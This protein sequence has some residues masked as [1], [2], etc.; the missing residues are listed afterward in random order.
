MY[1]PMHTSSSSLSC[2]RSGLSP[3]LSLSSP[4]SCP[5][6][7]MTSAGSNRICG[8]ITSTPASSSPCHRW[9]SI[10]RPGGSLL[11]SCLLC[12]SICTVQKA[13][14]M[15]R[16][17]SCIFSSLAAQRLRRSRPRRFRRWARRPGKIC[18]RC[19]SR[20]RRGCRWKGPWP[21]WLCRWKA[22]SLAHPCRT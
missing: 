11:S 3:L 12:I 19:L 8:R 14:L 17:S 10:F 20:R 9:G 15:C 21:S 2:F 18:L 7:G 13:S 5:T 22:W 1:K 6:T 4:A 16:C